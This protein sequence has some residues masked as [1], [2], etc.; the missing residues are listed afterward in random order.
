VQHAVRDSRFT[1]VKQTR[2]LGWVNNSNFLLQ[3]A[4]ADY[5]LF[6]FHDDLLLD[7]YFARLAAVLDEQPEAVMAF[8][9]MLLTHPS[10]EQERSV[11]TELEGIADAAERGLT[12]LRQKGAWWVPNRG[13]FRLAAARRV[14][15]LRRHAAGEVSADLPWLFHLALLG[16]FA[17]VPGFLCHKFYRPDSLSRTWQGTRS[18]HREAMAACMRELWNS[19]LSTDDK[20]KVAGPLLRRLAAGTPGN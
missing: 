3:M 12:M 4:K 20:V 18:E 6:A 19:P 8:S 16:R 2:R 7:G 5:L 10:G 15:G 13:M 11:Y 1:I 9:D 14:G 17:R